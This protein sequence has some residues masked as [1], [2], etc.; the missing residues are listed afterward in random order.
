M[1][2]TESIITKC[3]SELFFTV[4]NCLLYTYSVYML[5]AYFTLIIF[6]NN[7]NAFAWET[8]YIHSVQTL[9]AAATALGQIM[10]PGINCFTSGIKLFCFASTLHG[11]MM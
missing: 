6:D 8:P 11:D 4:Y 3:H 5:R 10:I 2:N 7:L 1:T 9:T